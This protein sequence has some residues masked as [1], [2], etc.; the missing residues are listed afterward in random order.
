MWNVG[1]GT[2]SSLQAPST[3]RRLP[4][5]SPSR[6]ANLQDITLR[7]ATEITLSQ[8]GTPSRLLGL[9][10]FASSQHAPRGFPDLMDGRE[11]LE[12][13][14]GLGDD[15]VPPRSFGIEHEPSMSIE[16]GRRASSVRGGDVSMM[17]E[18]MPDMDNNSMTDA[19]KGLPDASLL[20][21]ADYA[22]E[23]MGD[24]PIAA[25]A[26]VPLINEPFADWE[27]PPTP[28]G[29]AAADVEPFPT[30]MVDAAA[31]RAKKQTVKRTAPLASRKRKLAVD[32]ET[33]MSITDL[34]DTHDI[35]TTVCTLY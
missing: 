1:N 2:P 17:L 14:F 21:M 30:A 4:P 23:Y 24:D 34:R 10:D 9:A 28:N 32:Q 15:F 5:A 26:T 31:P 16:V 20:S 27:M 22:D 35:I 25:N 11:P 18:D 3:P 12:L 8:H 6:T 7:E 19:G 13:E 33:E 29:E